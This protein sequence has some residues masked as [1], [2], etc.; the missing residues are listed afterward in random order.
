M[1]VDGSDE[2]DHAG[3]ADKSH[4]CPWKPDAAGHCLVKS[5]AP[6]FGR[7]KKAGEE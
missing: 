4:R 2:P 5:W 1:A 7:K 3:I 6:E